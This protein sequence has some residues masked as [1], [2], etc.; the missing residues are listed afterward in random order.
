MFGPL[1]SRGDTRVIVLTIIL[2]HVNIGMTHVYND[3]ISSVLLQLI[4]FC[5]P[6]NKEFTDI[7]FIC[8]YL[9]TTK[10][11][12]T[13]YINIT[14][15]M[16]WTNPVTKSLHLYLVRHH[17]C[18]INCRPL[19]PSNFIICVSFRC[20]IFHFFSRIRYRQVMGSKQL[21]GQ[22]VWKHGSS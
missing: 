18:W 11:H 14:Q 12:L 20:F 5:V 3:D 4:T 10:K 16:Q 1:L 9:D 7:I 2:H 6:K 15:T 17:L 13:T 8:T 19:N 21:C 22:P